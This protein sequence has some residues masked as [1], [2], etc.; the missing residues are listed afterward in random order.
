MLASARLAGRWRVD[1]KGAVKRGT[2]LL[3]KHPDGRS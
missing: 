3:E 1:S 2:I